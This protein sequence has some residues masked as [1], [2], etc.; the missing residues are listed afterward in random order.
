[1]LGREEPAHQ[2]SVAEGRDRR[3]EEDREDA[4]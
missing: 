1:M 2:E 3:H 4:G